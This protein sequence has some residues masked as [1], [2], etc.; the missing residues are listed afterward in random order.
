VWHESLN[1]CSWRGLVNEIQEKLRLTLRSG[2]PSGCPCSYYA[3]DF[4]I[5]EFQ[6]LVTCHASDTKPNKTNF[7]EALC[8]TAYRLRQ[9]GPVIGLNIGGLGPT[10]LSCNN[11]KFTY[12]ILK[13]SVPISC[14]NIPTGENW[15]SQGSDY[16][17]DFWCETPCSL[18]DNKL[19]EESTASVSSLKMEAVGSSEPV[20]LHGVISHKTAICTAS[21]LRWPTGWFV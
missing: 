3:R 10:A 9:I 15:C 4:S 14:Q 7:N 2:A 17:C 21:W 13:H 1:P 11:I 6:N 5:T 8:T 16:D 19:S 18:A 12:I 20:R